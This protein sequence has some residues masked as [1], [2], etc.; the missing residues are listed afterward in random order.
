MWPR[1]IACAVVLS[2]LAGVCWYIDDAGYE[3]GQRELREEVQKTA[4]EAA[5]RNAAAHKKQIETL[6]EAHDAKEKHLQTISDDHAGAL[7]ELGRLRAAA[8][9]WRSSSM[10]GANSS[11]VSDNSDPIEDLLGKCGAELV[12]VAKAADD[13]AADALMCIQAWPR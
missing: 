9:A 7:R 4:D 13:H 2:I 12:R 6:M 8:S 1:L 3:R 5:E 10:L 11:A